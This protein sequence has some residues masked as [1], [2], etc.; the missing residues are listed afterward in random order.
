LPFTGNRLVSGWQISQIFSATSGLPV[1][2]QNGVPQSNLRGIQ[3][4]R[5]NHSN[6]PGCNPDHIVGRVDQ[7]FDPGCYALQPFGTLGNVSRD[8]INGPGLVDLDVAILKQTR[9][10]ERLDS[11]FRVEVFNAAN[12][13]NFSQPSTQYSRDFLLFP[14]RWRAVSLALRLRR[15][16]CSSG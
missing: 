9:I 1:N 3:G 6:A 8:S 13:P 7:W 15:G 12:H 5:P 11:Q 2:I 10:S 16:N 14:I 4:D